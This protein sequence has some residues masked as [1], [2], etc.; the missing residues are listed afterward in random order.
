MNELTQS[1][2][3]FP[4]FMDWHFTWVQCHFIRRRQW[5]CITCRVWLENR[6]S[7]V[8]WIKNPVRLLSKFSFH[9]V[10]LSTSTCTNNRE[11]SICVFILY[12]LYWKRNDNECLC[13]QESGNIITS[14]VSPESRE[15]LSMIISF[16]LVIVSFGK[17]MGR[18]WEKCRTVLYLPFTLPLWHLHCV[19][20]SLI[21]QEYTEI[22]VF[23]G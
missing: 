9:V 17:R 15:D 14:Y 22:G 2:V 23:S 10:T 21:R 3:C 6:R 13:S 5:D 11:K 16:V 1:Y 7:G 12:A 4:F 8:N 19:R 18:E 20:F